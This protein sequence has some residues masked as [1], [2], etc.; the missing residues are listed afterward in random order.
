MPKVRLE[1]SKYMSKTI[2]FTITS[3]GI[4]C[5]VKLDDKTAKTWGHHHR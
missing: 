4:T 5:E 1:D 2:Y 3:P